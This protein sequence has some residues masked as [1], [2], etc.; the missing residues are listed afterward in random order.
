MTS[1]LQARIASHY[2]S[3]SRGERRLADFLRE[4]PARLESHPVASLAEEAGVSKATASRLFKRLGYDSVR[5]A[6]SSA[7][8]RGDTR[9]TGPSD[10]MLDRFSDIDTEN[11]RLSFANLDR[12]DLLRALDMMTACRKLWIVGFDHDYPLAH[13]AR[14]MMIRILPDIRMI[15]LP[16]FSVP[17]ELASLSSDD[18]ILALG[19]HGLTPRAR[20]VLRVARSIGTPAVLVA[21]QFARS[22]EDLAEIVLRCRTKS[23]GGVFDSL[24]APASLLT[25]L[26]TCLTDRLGVSALDRL[27]RIESFQN[28]WDSYI[29]DR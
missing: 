29:V 19:V 7:L 6:K 1:D 28:D 27:Q 16:G 18:A 8:A 11:L 23:A 3:L 25:Y 13:M 14:T 20:A 26:C 15:P 4:R 10:G 2:D 5:D 21:D 22:G 24:A 9:T 17:E 12:S